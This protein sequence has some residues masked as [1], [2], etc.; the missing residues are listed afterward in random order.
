MNWLK[1]LFTPK[2]PKMIKIDLVILRVRC[3]TTD[4]LTHEVV[5]K[6]CRDEDD[7]YIPYEKAIHTHRRNMASGLRVE[8]DGVPTY[9]PP[10]SIVRCQIL[11]RKELIEEFSEEE[12]PW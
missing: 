4:G 11:E 1:K 12:L 8:L 6:G 2:P 5:L 10:G 9:Y 7:P 3:L